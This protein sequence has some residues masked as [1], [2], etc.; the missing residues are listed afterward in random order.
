MNFLCINTTLTLA[1]IVIISQPLSG[2]EH[3]GKLSSRL[4]RWM[5]SI[6][7]EYIPLEYFNR[8]S[9]ADLT[10]Q[11]LQSLLRNF[12]ENLQKNL[13]TSAMLNVVDHQSNQN[14][15]RKLWELTNFFY[16]SADV[17]KSFA[18]D[19]QL[20]YEVAKNSSYTLL[21]HLR[22]IPSTQPTLVKLLLTNYFEEMEF[23]HI[24]FS[25]IIDEILEYTQNTLLLIQNT[26]IYYADIQRFILENWNLKRNISCITEYMEF[27]QPCSAKVFKCTTDAKL[28]VVF[29]VFAMTQ[30]TNKYVMRQLEFRIQRLFNCFYFGNY[31]IRCKFLENA[32]RDFETLFNKIYDLEIYYDIKTKNG[33]V[34]PL[35]LR[36]QSYQYNE[37][38]TNALGVHTDC[39]P[40]DFPLSKM[41]KSL[42]NCFDTIK[43]Y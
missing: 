6:R 12:L 17:V 8:M 3:V 10:K 42:K 29:D 11:D 20:Y 22:Q 40:K 39:I 26:F 5:Q 25:E 30:L 7:G 16:L 41:R 34:S 9:S 33:R 21:L 38:D 15:I 36:R 31:E 32:E 23:F 28:D 35:R 24:M 43:K 19:S 14:Q 18:H 13:T 27:L 4:E 1:F 37:E 2:N